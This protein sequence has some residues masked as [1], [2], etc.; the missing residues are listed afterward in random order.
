M[1][2]KKKTGSRIRIKRQKNQTPS[3]ITEFKKILVGIIILSFICL[4]IAMTAD[5]FLGAH[6]L[7]KQGKLVTDHTG[8]MEIRD[9]KGKPENIRKY[10]IFE[11]I[12]NT[13]LEK[14]VQQQSNIPKIAIIIDDI[15]YDKE[16]SLALCNLNSNITFSVLPFAPFG[17]LLSE[18][19]YSNGSQ[20]MLHLP[21]EPVEYPKFNPGPGAIL[22]MM[23]PD[24][25]I[26][27]LRDNLKAVPHIAG[28]NNHMGSKLTSNSDQMNQI[29][30]ILKKEN[31]FFV[32]SRTSAKSQCKPS[33]R[34]LKVKFAQR[35]VFLD[36]FQ[37][38]EYIT[39]QL[40]KLIDLAKK[41]GSA[42]GIGHPYQ[43]TLEAL[44][45]E[46]PTLKGKVKIVRASF[47]TS[48]PG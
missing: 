20:L 15:G 19:L 9:I 36:N 44:S 41:N 33:A 35:D 11:D 2:A 21:M 28:V 29:F 42:I 34:L 23:P 48:V 45:K 25:L 24:I 17:K 39:G 10:E 4:A 40:Q 46:L 12:D 16:I 1:A 6:S 13:V 3:L 47:L 31:L 22:S 30:T 26:S 8:R 18:K 27:Q 7:E 38:P 32:D 43:E 5:I 14:P 37:T